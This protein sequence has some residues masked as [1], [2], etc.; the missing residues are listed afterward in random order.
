MIDADYDGSNHA[1]EIN[2][3]RY[4]GYVFFSAMFLYFN[5]YPAWITKESILLFKQFWNYYSF[6]RRTF[7][8]A[9]KRLCCKEIE[10]S[11]SRLIGY[12]WQSR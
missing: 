12:F 2:T 10:Q 7:E 6:Q 4:L 11:E 5:L 1:E 9:H 8:R 3:T